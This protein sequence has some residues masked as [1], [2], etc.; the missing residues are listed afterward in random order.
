MP[1][2]AKR[3]QY[4]IGTYA[5]NMG[6]TPDLLKHYE[7][8]GLLHAQ[9]AENGYRYYP[10]SESVPLLECFSLRGYE[11][12]LQQMRDLLY[13]GTLEN[14]HEVLDERAQALRNRVLRDQ[15]VLREYEAFDRWM[16]RMEHR[17]IY[18]L[19]EEKEDV[20]FLPHSKERD[21]LQDSRIRELLPRWIEWMPAVKSCRRI[22]W[23]PD[24]HGVADS[25]WGLSVPVPVAEE[26]GIPLNDVVERLPGGRQLICH[27]RA[28]LTPRQSGN[29]VWTQVQEELSK[30]S[31]KPS[32]PIRQTVLASLFS[33]E[34]RTACGFYAIPMDESWRECTT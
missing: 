20:Y 21:F 30:A 13:G 34:N 29:A 11:M 16:K 32:G 10:F 23:Q 25:Y 17:S 1:D 14:L 12:P 18:M 24:E 28:H 26:C 19:M 2:E 8:K 31:L 7:K 33:T 27:Y 3:R 15:I 5:Q 9:T 4:R 22:S 6:V